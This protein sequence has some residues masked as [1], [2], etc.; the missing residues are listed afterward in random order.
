MRNA[1]HILVSTGPPLPE[2]QSARGVIDRQLQIMTRLLEDL[3]DVLADLANKM[4]LRNEH[5]QLA[6]VID[7]ALETSRP[8]IEAAQA[9]VRG[10]VAS[11]TDSPGRRSGAAGAGLL[12]PA[13]QRRQVHRGGGPISLTAE[14]QGNDVVVDGQGQR[15]RHPPEMLPR[16]FE[17]FAQVDRDRWTGRRAGL[18]IGL[19]LVKRL[20]ELHGGSITAK[21]E[22]VGRGS[23][24]VVRLP[25][26]VRPAAPSRPD[27][28][29]RQ[30]A[31]APPRRILVVDD[32]VDSADSSRQLLTILGHETGTAYDGEA[33]IAAAR[34]HPAR[35]RAARYR[36]AETQWL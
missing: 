29:G 11:R 26:S 7:S 22:G 16:I 18:G 34:R 15:H 32:N 6:A 1:M 14:R 28:P 4:E 12:Q 10:R 9:F 17:M 2:L 30:A 36:H 33:A 3:L 25:I 20:V 13:E 19:S 24:F 5:V 8:V 27:P 31:N 21:S 35:C 23:E